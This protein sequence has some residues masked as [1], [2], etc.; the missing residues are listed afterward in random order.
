MKTS[1]EHYKTATAKKLLVH[2]FRLLA[3]ASGVRFDSDNDVEIEA[4]V[5]SIVDAVSAPAPT[6]PKKSD[7]ENFVEACARF[8]G[9][10]TEQT[11]GNVWIAYKETEAGFVVFGEESASLYA[12]RKAFDDGESP[13]A[14][15]YFY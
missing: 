7:G 14:T 15:I 4:I 6:E 12:L 11:G 9:M 3:N 1:A 13:L 8:L 5:D 2:Y 10:E